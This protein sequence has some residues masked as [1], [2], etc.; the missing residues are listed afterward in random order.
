L[1]NHQDNPRNLKSLHAQLAEAKAKIQKVKCANAAMA[2][3]KLEITKITMSKFGFSF[4]WKRL[5]GVTSAKQR[6]SRKTDFSR[7]W[8]NSRISCWEIFI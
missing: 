8:R 5:L 1:K 2:K 4:S 7:R 6:I 3:V